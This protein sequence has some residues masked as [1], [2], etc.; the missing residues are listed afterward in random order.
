MTALARSSRDHRGHFFADPP[1]PIS[2]VMGGTDSRSATFSPRI[3]HSIPLP[4]EA[5]YQSGF[6]YSSNEC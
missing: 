4:S 2:V 3:G 1:G 5:V 6:H